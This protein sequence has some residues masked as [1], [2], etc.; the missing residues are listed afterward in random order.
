MIGSLV[1][2]YSGARTFMGRADA[3]KL[4]RVAATGEFL[5]LHNAVELTT[6]HLPAMVRPKI[7]GAEPEIIV[8]HVVSDCFPDGLP[9]AIPLLNVRVDGYYHVSRL[10]PEMTRGIFLAYDKLTGGNEKP[11][12]NTEPPSDSGQSLANGLGEPLV[13]TE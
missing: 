1:V 11:A 10:P 2:V 7:A 8:Q 9:C 6:L 4:Q 12:A 5:W 13:T 3:E